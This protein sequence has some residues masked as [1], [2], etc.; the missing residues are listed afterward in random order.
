M[1][2]KKKRSPMR[3]TDSG[4]QLLLRIPQPMLEAL[5]EWCG[6][7]LDRPSRQEAIRRMVAHFFRERRSTQPEPP[8]P[9]RKRKD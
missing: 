8:P 9:K 3:A 5:D 4:D 1:I 6:Q 7:Q 2:K